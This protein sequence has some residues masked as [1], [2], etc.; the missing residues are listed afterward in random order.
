MIDLTEVERLILKS[1]LGDRRAFAA[2]YAATSS[3]LFGLCLRVL[4]NRSEAEEVLQEAYVKIWRNAAVYAADGL[5]PWAWLMTVTRNTAIDRL[6][7][8]RATAPLDEVAELADLAPGPEDAALARGES[9]RI[10]ACLDSLEPDRAEAV[11][12]AYLRGETYAELAR[13]FGV[14]LNTMRTWLRRSLIRLRE[15][16]SP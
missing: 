14:P 13:R 9:R 1:G 11:R 2:L 4:D 3:K 8:R 16:L 7:A 12:R 5:S 10:A 15:C 6:R